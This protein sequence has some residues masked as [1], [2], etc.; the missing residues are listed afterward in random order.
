MRGKSKEEGCLCLKEPKLR[1]AKEC[2]IRLSVC[3]CA[4]AR[5]KMKKKQK[6]QRK[7]IGM[8]KGCEN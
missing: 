2:P 6:K 8:I 7:G 5:K 4:R 1:K 3:V